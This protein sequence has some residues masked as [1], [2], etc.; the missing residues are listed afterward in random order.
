MDFKAWVRRRAFSIWLRT[1]TVPNWL[2]AAPAELKFNPWHDLENGKFTFAGTGGYFG[3]ESGRAAASDR[4]LA[5]S[6]GQQGKPGPGSGRKPQATAK[7][8]APQ[9]RPSG[10]GFSGRGGSF[11]GAGA[12]GVIPKAE[13]PQPREQPAP[14]ERKPEDSQRPELRKTPAVR[15]SGDEEW[16]R[17]ERNGYV[18]FIDRR[19]RTCEVSGVLTLKQAA[20]SRT[21]QARA[22]VPDRRPKD[23]GG[24]YIASRFNGPSEAF[25]HF[26]QD[27]TFN[28]GSYRALEDQWAR[29]IRAGKQVK[30]RIEPIYEGS[31]RRPSFLNVWFRIDGERQ[32][33]QYPNEQQEKIRARQ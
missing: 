4:P 33:V 31:S 5:R 30:V 8:G 21:A 20:R 19:N 12:S 26:A 18:F 22:G 17:V 6:H 24:H 25:N 11:G 27:P 29:A 32:S 1:G 16:R 2:T 7:V 15:Q 14:R 13:I 10:R 28:R 23:D 3:R 9:S